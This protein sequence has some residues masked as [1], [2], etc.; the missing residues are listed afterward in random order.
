[1]QPND[2]RAA[3]YGG[4]LAVG[5]CTGVYTAEELRQASS[6]SAVILPDLTDTGAFL[7]LLDLDGW[8][9]CS[10]TLPIDCF[11]SRALLALGTSAYC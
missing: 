2:I 1:M 5:V 7:K 3:E 8:G 11:N 10:I 4:A 9:G 6:G